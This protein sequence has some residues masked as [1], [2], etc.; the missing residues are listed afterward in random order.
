[1][2]VQNQGMIF[3]AGRLAHLLRDQAEELRQ[4]RLLLILALMG[5]FVAFLLT[6]YFLFYRRTLKSLDSLQ[7]GATL[8]GSG[9]FSHVIDESSDDEIGDLARSFNRMTVNLRNVTA[10]KS[11]LEQEVA[12]RKRAEQNLETR[13]EELNAINEELTATQEE[14]HQNIEE[15]TKAEQEVRTSREQY[16]NLF[17]TMAEGFAVH[18]I[19]VDDQGTPVDYR[20]LLSTRHLRSSPG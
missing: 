15:L 18:E 12:E 14:L 10:S 2:A 19:I 3:D 1:M 7:D 11:D 8:V 17:E 13:N 4:T 9:D 20:F 16:R 6:S 5:T